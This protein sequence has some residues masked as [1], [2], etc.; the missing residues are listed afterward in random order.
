MKFI[1]TGINKEE[2]RKKSRNSKFSRT[3]CGVHLQTNDKDIITG[4]M[5][6]D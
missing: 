1:L 6:T 4:A 5:N 2:H 3:F